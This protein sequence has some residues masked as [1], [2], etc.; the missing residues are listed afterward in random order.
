VSTQRAVLDADII[1]SRVLHEL[2]GR[3]AA[4]ARLF[5]LVWSE[6]LLDEAESSLI[7]RKG[8]STDAAQ[9]W[10]G[11]MRREFP[12]GGID[13]AGIPE[14]LDVASMTRDPGDAHVCALAIAGSADLLFT[15][16]RGYLKEPLRDHG[17]EVPDVDSFLIEQCEEQPQA[18]TRIVEAQ[19]EVW[20]GG[21]PLEELL[22]AFERA[23]VPG[24]VATLRP[25]LDLSR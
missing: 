17:V 8:L 16:D 11:H 5:D 10:V 6:E 2:M 24:F 14:D 15:F 12:S 22:V 18:I 1:F 3:L 7:E 23:N 20:S 25:L 9:S 4:G 13:L 19:P 21:R